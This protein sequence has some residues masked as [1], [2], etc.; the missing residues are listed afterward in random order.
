MKGKQTDRTATFEIWRKNNINNFGDFIWIQINYN[1]H[2]ADT[3]SVIFEEKDGLNLNIEEVKSKLKLNNIKCCVLNFIN[4]KSIYY[5][6]GNDLHNRI[7]LV[8][9][10]QLSSK[11]DTYWDYRLKTLPQNCLTTDIDSL[12]ITKTQFVGIEAAQLF[13]T[14]NL[15]RAMPHIF[16]TFK[17]RKN[18]VNEKQYLAQHK[19][20]QQIGGKAF[21]LFHK[22]NQNNTLNET[23]PVFLIENNVEFYNMLC[24]IKR[25][26]NESSF[27]KLYQLYLTSNMK[28]YDNI[29]SAYEYIKNL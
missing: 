8:L 14:T 13:D 26:S 23:S 16:R 22:I 7:G 25:L 28:Q 20:M 1:E 24:D 6:D 11:V 29:Y 27:I 12:E 19:L 2:S 4:D 10:K 17:F 5:T 9:S 15:D 18:K 3:L 21:V